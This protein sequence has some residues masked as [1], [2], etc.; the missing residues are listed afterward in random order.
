MLFFGAAQDMVDFL[1][2]KHTLWSH[3]QF[4]HP[5]VC[6]HL[7][8]QNCKRF[9]WLHSQS[10]SKTLCLVSFPSSR[11]AALLGLVLTAESCGWTDLH[12]VVMKVLSSVFN[13]Q[14]LKATTHYWLPLDLKLLTATVWMW[15][16]SRFLIQQLFLVHN[17]ISLSATML[18]GT[19]PKV[20]QKPR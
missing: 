14:N 4:F 8:L 11:W 5:P 19:V 9:R 2:C 18:S 1:N 16:F 3:V 20:W 17:F 6:F 7:A 13:I 12:S 10:L 15:P